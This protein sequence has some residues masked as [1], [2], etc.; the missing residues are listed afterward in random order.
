M[1][2]IFDEVDEELRADRAQALLRR[3]G[4]VIIGA[5]LLIV[6]AAGGWQAWRS[7]RHKQD[8]SIATEY[9]AATRLADVAGPARATG[10]PEAIAAFE[11]VAAH[12]PEGYRTLA[13]LRAAALKADGGDME[14]AA[15]IWDQVAGDGAADPL[16][17][18]LANVTWANRLLDKGDPALIEARLKPLTAPDN[19]WRPLARETE[20][21]LSL[22]EGKTQQA[23]DSFR[24]LAQD[25]T[26]P[27]GV[28]TRAN[29]V[30]NRLGG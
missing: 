6:G 24:A 19:P 27:Q 17:R 15:A 22:R 11:K 16:I 25:V 9:I 28:R 21:L 20:A 13:R 2:D 5:A 30:M 7:W 3:Y 10:R 8:L 14:G 12:A 4:W 26:A 23:K 29:I 18:D 1:T